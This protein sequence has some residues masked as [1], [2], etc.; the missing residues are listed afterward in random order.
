MQQQRRWLS[1]DNQIFAQFPIFM[2]KIHYTLLLLLC[3]GFSSSYAQDLTFSIVSST[4]TVSQGDE[5]TVDI[6]VENFNNILSMEYSLVWDA[7]SLEYVSTDN[8]T[9]ELPAFSGNTI[10][11]IPNNTD[12]GTIKVSWVDFANFQPY[13]LPDNT[14]LFSVTFRAIADGDVT[15]GLDGFEVFDGDE[16]NPPFVANGTNITVGEGG[17]TGNEDGL[18]ISVGNA[19]DTTG[20]QVCLPV[21]ATGFTDLESVQFSMSYDEDLLSFQQVQNFNEPFGAGNFGTP[22]DQPEGTIRVSWSNMEGGSSSV[23]D[24]TVLFEICFDI[25]GTEDENTTVSITDSPLTREAIQAVTGPIDFDSSNGRV[26][27]EAVDDNNG[28]G[29]SEEFEI[30]APTIEAAAGS[31]V[32]VDVQVDGFQDIAGLQYSMMWSTDILRFIEVRNFNNNFTDFGE[33]NIGEEDTNDGILRVQWNDFSFV[34]VT[35][36]DE[37]TIFQIC[38]EVVGDAGQNSVIGFTSTPLNQEVINTDTEE[39]DFNSRNG[40]VNVSG[41]PPPPSDC[42]EDATPICISK[43]TAGIDEEVCVV[44]TAQNFDDISSAQMTITFDNTIVRFQEIR[45]PEANPLGLASEGNFGVRAAPAGVISFQ[46]SNSEASNISLPDDTELFFLCFTGRMEGTSPI[47]FSDRPT[48]IEVGDIDFN[49][50]PFSGG[51]GEIVIGETNA[52]V[53]PNATSEVINV[54]CAGESTGSIALILAGGNANYS[55]AW[56]EGISANTANPQNLAAGTYDVTISQTADGCPETQELSFTIEEPTTALSLEAEVSGEVICFGDEN[57]AINLTVAGGTGDYDYVWQAP[58]NNI[59]ISGASASDLPAGEYGVRVT[60]ENGC[61]IERQIIVP[62]P[63]QAVTINSNI[64]DIS[65]EGETSGAIQLEVTG[66]VGDYTFEWE[67]ADGLGDSGTI[68]DLTAGNYSVTVTDA[69][70]CT[71]ISNNLSV[72]AFTGSPITLADAEVVSIIEGDDG[73]INLA[74]EGGSGNLTFAW[75]GPDYTNNTQNISDLSAAGV[76]EVTITDETTGCVIMESFEVQMGSAELLFES[77]EA[78]PDCGGE[79]GNTGQISVVLSG[80]IPPLTFSWRNG[81]TE[82]ATTQNL[83]NVAAGSYV[84]LVTDSRENTFSSDTITVGTA[85]AINYSLTTVAESCNDRSD[86]GSIQLA[87]T[88][89]TGTLTWSWSGD[90]ADN[91]DTISNLSNGNYVVTIT[92]ESGCQVIDTA[93]VDLVTEAPRAMNYEIIEATCG[94][95]DGSIAFNIVCGEPGYNVRIQGRRMDNDTMYML[96][97]D[98]FNA[99][100]LL[101]NLPPDTYD[102]TIVD[103]TEL[104]TNDVITIPAAG[105]ID[106]VADVRSSTEVFSPCDGEIRLNA[107]SGGSG[108]NFT[109]QWSNEATTRNIIDLCEGLYI[110]TITNEEGCTRIDSFDVQTLSASG[111]IDS[112]ECDSGDTTGAINLRVD[113]GQGPFTYEW[114][115]MENGTMR[116]DTSEDLTSIEA[117]IYTVR[118]T[119]V[120]GVSITRVFEVKG[121][122]RLNVKMTFGADYRGFGVSCNGA[123]DAILLA[124]GESV[125]SSAMLTY[126]WVNSAR[127]TISRS[128][129]L[130]NVGADIYEVL[131]SD[132]SCTVSA[133]LAVTEPAAIIIN[134]I[135][136]VSSSCAGDADANGEAMVV[137]SGGAGNPYTYNW[138]EPVPEDNNFPTAIGLAGGNYAVTVTDRNGCS[139]VESFS[140]AETTPITLETSF[141]PI[142]SSGGGSIT[143]VVSGGTPMNG[144]RYVWEGPN[145]MGIIN[146]N[147]RDSMIDKLTEAGEYFLMVEDFNGCTVMT[148]VN[149]PNQD[150]C[151]ETRSIITPNGDG[152]NE[153]FG[154][155][156]VESY[157]DTRLEI[158]NRWGTAVFNQSNYDGQWAGTNGNGETV[159]DGVYF[160]VLIYT[161]FDGE[162]KQQQGTVTVLTK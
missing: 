13:S 80:G 53:P 149:L 108:R 49:V 71:S 137:V 131:V 142:S 69:N 88:G 162:E 99:R 44:V 59:N 18:N 63:T 84:L 140:I 136:I 105:D 52:C 41:D 116:T 158:Y 143:A 46:W 32:C 61:T 122:G 96:D 68:T 126:A 7:N 40:R 57:G 90:I 14:I 12:N 6:E 79:N 120:S 4:T 112:P 132:G 101:E 107:P 29:T 42:D 124:E 75:T 133:R 125:D 3:L 129:E 81:E 9:T 56:S 26:T 31:T 141:I 15:I 1:Y 98:E 50:V 39:I 11:D 160:Y 95:T 43:E 114:T 76:Y 21:T 54:S 151:L 5:F 94:S 28:G 35:L 67:G 157:K 153:T 66:G 2:K 113:N 77:I 73:A 117:G 146:N 19:S 127:D 17:G 91:Q 150:G 16:N 55:F 115:W 147:P 70:G 38:F 102:V 37:S 65:C 103:F 20:A 121:N 130:D 86:N 109:Y 87:A 8:I 156:C 27:I 152:K 60:D 72:E 58:N 45:F 118:V 104:S 134:E 123:E 82:V 30:Y 135:D 85:P 100:V 22:P 10:G 138:S 92:D 139:V 47:G 51:T 145:M 48:A 159:A 78:A 111:I 89:G 155:R 110:V 93:I 24:G 36:P 23:D 97:F 148:T 119:E 62:G 106:L 161:D 154:I 144:Y 25:T 83:N 33:Q 128:A 34:G 64:R 74:I